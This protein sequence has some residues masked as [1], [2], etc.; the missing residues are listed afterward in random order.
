VPAAN[1]SIPSLQTD[2]DFIGP[3]DSEI[4]MNWPTLTKSFVMAGVMFLNFTFYAAS[5]IFTESI[6][7]IEE[8]F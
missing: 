3:N 1:A 6:P 5:A 4:P 8:K 2:F 7:L